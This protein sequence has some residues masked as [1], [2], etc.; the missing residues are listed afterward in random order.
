MTRFFVP[1][2]SGEEAELVYARLAAGCGR[3]VPLHGDRIHEIQWTRDSDYWVATVGVQLRGQRVRVGRRGGE[4][5]E[6]SEQLKDLATVR[7]IFP[8][9]PYMVV[10]DARRLGPFISYW[11]NPFTV[12]QPTD[13]V[14]FEQP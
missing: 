9:D 3:E 6:I 4:Y 5:I 11:N 14:K 13:I 12:G 8:G 7:A 10:T 2:T 1:G